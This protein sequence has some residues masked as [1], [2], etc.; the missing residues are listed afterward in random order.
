MLLRL[1][2]IV[3]KIYENF[4]YNAAKIYGDINFTAIVR[5]LFD[6]LMAQR[7]FASRAYA[8]IAQ[9]VYH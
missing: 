6:V 8:Y 2:K 5:Y 1:S 7:L 4:S 3:L 9:N